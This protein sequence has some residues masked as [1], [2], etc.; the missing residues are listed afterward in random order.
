MRRKTGGGQGKLEKLEHH[1]VD[2]DDLVE[3]DDDDMF[4]M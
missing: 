4:D 2:N 3:L 1:R